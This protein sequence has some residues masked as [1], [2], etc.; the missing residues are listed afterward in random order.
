MITRPPLVSGFRCHHCS[1]AA[2]E[3]AGQ[4]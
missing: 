3:R 4:S 1:Y 2:A